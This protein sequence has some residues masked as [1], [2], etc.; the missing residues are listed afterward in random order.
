MGDIPSQ[1]VKTGNPATALRHRREVFLQITIPLA[2][3]I[4]IVLALAVMTAVGVTAATQ[5]QMADAALVELITPVLIF[6]VITLL[7]LGAS[8]YGLVRLI[9]IAPYY[10]LRAQIFFLRIQLGVM[11]V[12]NRLVEPILR[13]HGFAAQ[14]RAFGRSLRHAI[15]FK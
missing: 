9:L 15:G 4:I 12:D 10:F 1:P 6:C 11:R 2:I 5:S 8:I 14:T 3:G 13:T 7:I